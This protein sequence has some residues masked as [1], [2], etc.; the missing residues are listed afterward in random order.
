MAV[1]IN[2]DSSGGGGSGSY[3]F[4]GL[5][6]GVAMAIAVVVGSSSPPD[7]RNNPKH[8]ED[9]EYGRHDHRYRGRAEAR[10]A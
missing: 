8:Y 1:I 3:T 7:T 6:L 5:I 4:L 10:E 9:D 2:K